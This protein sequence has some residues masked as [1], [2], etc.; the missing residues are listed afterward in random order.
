MKAL[1]VLVL[2]G[3][4]VVGATATLGLVDW[5]AIVEKASTRVLGTERAPNLGGTD[6]EQEGSDGSAAAPTRERKYIVS[7]TTSIENG[8]TRYHVR[9][10]RAG[11]A[12]L[13]DQLDTAWD[14][15]V[16][17]GVP[18]LAGLR[19][20]FMCHPLSFVAR[21][22]R[23]WDLESWRPTVGLKRTMLELCNPR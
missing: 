22:K 5:V 10:T 21:G 6:S 23:S 7:V 12:A 2:I 1:V 4:L 20:Q 16:G 15:A 17:R 9:P 11:R 18:D 14:Q 8:A 3:A 19:Q 13:G